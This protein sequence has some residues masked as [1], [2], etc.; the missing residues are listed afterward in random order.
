[1]SDSARWRARWLLV[2]TLT[3]VAPIAAAV[4]A[5]V[6][7]AQGL[8]LG[9]IAVES[10]AGEPLRAVID[11][12]SGA[13]GE[14]PVTV[15]VASRQ[16][17]EAMGL[18][19]DPVLESARATVERAADGRA[20]V[21]V[22]TDRPV[23]A[24][25][26]TLLLETQ[27]AAGRY[28]RSYRLR[29]GEAP[30]AAAAVSLPA[31]APVGVAADAGG[32]V[33]GASAAAA[34]GTSATAAGPGAGAGGVAPSATAGRDTAPAPPRAAAGVDA[35]IERVSVQRGDTLGGIAERVRPEGATLAQ[36]VVALYR[37][38]PSAFIGRNLHRVRA[39][40]ELAVPAPRQVA[41]VDGEA[42]RVLIREQWAAV[43][44]WEAAGRSAAGARTPSAAAASRAAG[45]RGEASA[46]QPPAPA[47]PAAGVAGDRLVVAAGSPREPPRARR[48]EQQAAFDAAMRESTSRIAELERNVGS[49]NTLIALK[50]QQEQALRGDLARL[51]EGGAGRPGLAAPAAGADDDAPIPGWVVAAAIALFA[52]LLGWLFLRRRARPKPQPASRTPDDDD[53]DL[54]PDFAERA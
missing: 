34:A 51:R 43:G 36:T 33:A 23:T 13:A 25:E 50:T 14:T 12:G 49:L 28:A 42:A 41:A 46:G 4:F 9:P 24:D 29:A 27:S 19:W 38:N 18:H 3:A 53:D 20:T 6:A 52:L 31:A 8:L 17:Y 5:P 26:L 7:A 2:A 10:K 37:A 1:M 22:T 54:L 44:G 48:A 11:A 32:T 30:V 16:R 39:G 47:P 15:E 21:R 40:A 35:T 45:G